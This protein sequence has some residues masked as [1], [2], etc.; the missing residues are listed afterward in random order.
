MDLI[1]K[2]Y[3]SIRRF[4]RVIFIYLYF[5]IHNLNKYSNNFKPVYIYF[6]KINSAVIINRLGNKQNLC[7]YININNELI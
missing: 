6:F 1:N 2:T 3:I 4:L 5:A 7:I